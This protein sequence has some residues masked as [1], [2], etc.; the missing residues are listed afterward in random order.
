MDEQFKR[1]RKL[2]A[3]LPVIGLPF[4]TLL[5]WALGGGSSS[6]EG[7][8]AA[9]GGGLNTKLPE[10]RL[11]EGNPDKLSLYDQALKDSLEREEA[12][13][14]DPYGRYGQTAFADSL[15]FADSLN[16]LLPGTYGIYSNGGTQRGTDQ[17]EA[18]LRSRLAELE[19]QLQDEGAGHSF[20]HEPEYD[21]P[22]NLD[23]LQASFQAGNVPSAAGEP[24]AELDKI[25]SMLEKVMDIQNPGRVSEKLKAESEKHRGQVYS[26]TAPPANA[27]A[28]FFGGEVGGRRSRTGTDSSNTAAKVVT[29]AFYELTDDVVMDNE[30]NKAI[31]AVVHETQTL[32]SGSTVK[33]RLVEDV[34]INGVLIPKGSYVFGACQLEGERMNIEVKAFRSKNSLFPVSLTVYDMDGIAGIKIPGAIGRDATKQ[35][36]DQAIQSLDFYTIDQSIGAQAASAGIQTAK[37]LFGRKTKLVRATVKAGYPVLLMDLNK[38]DQ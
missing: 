22:L 8:P 19:R 18:R 23:A 38:R 25:N 34:Y 15:H 14:A 36:A 33:M 13:N 6:Q 5:F 29:A 12:R 20:D 27:N 24:D 21:P 32:V 3:V 17:T 30:A 2:L 4:I 35:G 26:V 1:K 16:A 28:D 31:P 37:S 11:E 10:A 9:A 7:K